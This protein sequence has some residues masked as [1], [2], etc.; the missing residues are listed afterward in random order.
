MPHRVSA[1][2]RE[3]HFTFKVAS[4][5]QLVLREFSICRPARRRLLSRPGRLCVRYSG[6]CLKPPAFQFYADDFIGGT[7]GM[8]ADEVGHYIR[9]LCFQWSHGKISSDETTL[10][11]IAGGKVS[12]VV[13]AKFPRG[14]NK[15][16]EQERQ[17][18]AEYRDKQRLKGIASAKA[19]LNR[20]STAVEPRA[21]DVRLEPEGNSPSPSPS[22]SPVQEAA[23]QTNGASFPRIEEVVALGDRSGI[24][25]DQCEK[26][27]HHYE[28]M[29]W[30]DKN[31]NPI[32]NWN[33]KLMVWRTEARGRSFQ[34]QRT[35][36]QPSPQK[37]VLKIKNL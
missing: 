36:Q 4:D 24:P 5:A 16:L 28:S 22:P 21:V 34:D 27:W 13:R 9:L 14:K 10:E 25:K 6:E 33:S 37:P 18:Q 20:G 3:T 32:R 26:F 30:I 31:G 12:E 2:Y 35:P 15:R 7:V 11:R 23:K 8:S 1:L 29:G 17:K 19:R